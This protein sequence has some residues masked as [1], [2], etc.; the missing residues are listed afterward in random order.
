M[1]L[2]LLDAARA[3]TNAPVDCHV[4]LGRG[5][6]YCGDSRLLG[7]GLTSIAASPMWATLAR[8]EPLP[9]TALLMDVGND[10]LYG[11]DVPRILAH[12]EATLVH[13]VARAE[14]VIVAGLPLAAIQR[15]TTRQF[16]VV[17]TILLPRSPLTFAAAQRG[18]EQLQ[19]GLRTM[20]IRC[21]ATF[22]EPEL[23][24][25]GF[26]VVHVRRRHQHE[27]ARR[28]LAA[29]A[30]GPASPVDTALGRLRLLLT[31]PAERTWFGWRT[32]AAQPARRWRDGSTLSLW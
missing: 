1:A 23:A 15:V 16:L 20:A 17:R 24:W 30:N 29:P 22:Y 4:T 32:T 19:Q 6:S 18:A 7:R 28:W 25:Y 21:G 27:A 11:V 12:V 14:R 10:L 2:S 5:R 31:P 9:T 26:D 3:A 8:A 13:L